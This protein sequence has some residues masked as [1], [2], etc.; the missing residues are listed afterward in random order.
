MNPSLIPKEALLIPCQLY[1]NRA[2]C[3]FRLN[4]HLEVINDCTYVLNHIDKTNSKAYYRRAQ[5]L[6]SVHDYEGAVKD[7]EMC[8][9]LDTENEAAKLELNKILLKA[10]EQRKE[11]ERRNNKS[12]SSSS[13]TI[14]K[15]Q[16]RKEQTEFRGIDLN[17]ESE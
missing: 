2:L 9:K 12:S 1:T 6:T 7:L 4:D 10:V 15:E 11:R 8:L 13:N 3:N 5:S 16:E 14:N 17:K